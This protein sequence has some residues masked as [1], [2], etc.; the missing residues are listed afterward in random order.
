MNALQF[1]DATGLIYPRCS[2]CREKTGYGI[3]IDS[4][5]GERII[6]CPS[7]ME[8]AHNTICEGLKQLKKNVD[9]LKEE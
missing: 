3:T 9:C 7:C 5:E 1:R 6:F 2:I 8:E 4:Y